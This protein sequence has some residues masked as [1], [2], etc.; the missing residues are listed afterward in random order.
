M[1]EAKKNIEN[2]KTTTPFLWLER[3][4]G[5]DIAMS[6]LTKFLEEMEDAKQSDSGSN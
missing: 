2:V 4:Y 6:L 5:R 1:G 3:R